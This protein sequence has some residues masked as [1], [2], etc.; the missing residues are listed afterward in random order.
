M[1]GLA[2]RWSAGLAL[3]LAAWSA[4]AASVVEI[5]SLDSKL[6]IT[7]YWFPAKTAGAGPAVIGLH[8]CSGLKNAKGEL[9]V[10]F[11][12]R[13]AY[14]NAEGIHFLA[15]DSFG[16]RGQ[17]SICSTPNARRTIDEEMRREDV[18][19]AMKW[20][21]AQ[22]GV[23]AS[24]IIV[25][26]WSH[27]AQTVLS[28]MDASDKLVQAQPIKPRAGVAF[29]PGC[30]RYVRMFSYEISAPLLIMIGELDDWTPAAACETLARRLGKPGQPSFELVVY[31]GSYHGFDGT[32]PMQVRSD[33]G[34]TRSGK[35]TVGGNPEAREKAYARMFDFLSTQ[36]AQP[37]V[38]SHEQRLR[39]PVTP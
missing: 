30:S 16:A 19:A 20:L 23:D 6:N 15:V 34:N 32:A 38:L 27:G 33:I 22:P 11:K 28:V 10:G 13:A 12:Q 21:A 26:G 25:A 17:G 5:P 14:F 24:K 29:Y 31:P 9:A 1:D 18:F 37:L 35:A 3:A 2:R 7:A 36:L 8:G 4:Q 39:L